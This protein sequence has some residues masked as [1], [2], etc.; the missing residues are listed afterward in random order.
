MG[1][2]CVSCEETGFIYESTQAKT[3]SNEHV[4][5]DGSDFSDGGEGIESEGES[6]NEIAENRNDN[7]LES[8]CKVVKKRKTS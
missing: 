2:Y 7:N 5:P 3:P 8:D 6:N 4:S 1:R